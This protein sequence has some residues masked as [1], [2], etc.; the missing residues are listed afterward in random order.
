MLNGVLVTRLKLPP[1]IVTL[2]TL[3]VFTAITL[4]YSDGASVRGAD[5]PALLTWTGTVVRRSAACA[6]PPASS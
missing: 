4:L 3:N 2:G 5:L 1:F 6:S